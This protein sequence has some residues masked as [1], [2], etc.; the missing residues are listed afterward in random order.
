MNVTGFLI[1]DEQ[2]QEFVMVCKKPARQPGKVFALRGW[3][4]RRMIPLQCTEQE[5]RHIT[6][7]VLMTLEGLLQGLSNM[8]EDPLKR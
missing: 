3:Q 6:G 7:E 2:G 5:L 8:S 4:R 1:E